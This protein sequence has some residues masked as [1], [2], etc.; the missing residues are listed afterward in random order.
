[1]LS[2][3]K[4]LLLSLVRRSHL[5]G[6]HL[7]SGEIQHRRIKV[8]G[9][10]GTR[11]E[12]RGDVG[13]RS[14]CRRHGGER[15]WEHAGARGEVR[16]DRTQ[17]PGHLPRLPPQLPQPRAQTSAVPA[18][19]LQEVF[20]LALEESG[21]DWATA[22]LPAGWQG[23]QTTWVTLFTNKHTEHGSIVIVCARNTVEI[24]CGSLKLVCLRAHSFTHLSC[25]WL[26]IRLLCCHVSRRDLMWNVWFCRRSECDPLS[27][28]Q[29]GVYGG[30]CDGE[31]VR[32]GLGW[33]SQQHSG[34]DSPGWWQSVLPYGGSLV[35]GFYSYGCKRNPWHH[36]CSSDLMVFTLI[37]Q[38]P[39]YINSSSCFLS[40]IIILWYKE[41]DL[42][43][44]KKK[45]ERRW[46]FILMKKFP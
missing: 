13:G 15:G 25:F 41:D 24:H 43:Q 1:M 38:D 46:T 11:G 23:E 37:N 16:S 40:T 27:G 17:L 45:K 33:G 2:S 4:W 32:E 10:G 3:R 36:C 19:L 8:A 28:V 20:A 22:T 7:V 31:C 5:R 21:H 34:E 18:F 9:N 39:G 30:R 44:K 29:A 35:S 14:S 12:A 42:C 26:K 6:L